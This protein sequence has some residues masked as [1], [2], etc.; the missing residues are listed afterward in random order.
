L[1]NILKR[2]IHLVILLPDQDG[3]ELLGQ[4]VLTERLTLANPLAVVSDGLGLQKEDK[5]GAAE[6]ALGGIERAHPRFPGARK[7]EAPAALN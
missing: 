1:L 3:A 2:P 5:M 7:W 6:Q 4:S